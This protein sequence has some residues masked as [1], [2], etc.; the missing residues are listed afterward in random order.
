MKRAIFFTMTLTALL[1]T[2]CL[3]KRGS[4]NLI[5]EEREVS[6]FDRVE[7]AS[8]GELM[9]TQG[10]SESLIIEAEDN[11]MSYITS[12]VRGGTLVL[13]LKTRWWNQLI[14]R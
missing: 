6:D 5:T 1:F 2:A 7:L 8:D 13:G 4:G 9:L 3:G 12:E 10:G 11:V 14:P